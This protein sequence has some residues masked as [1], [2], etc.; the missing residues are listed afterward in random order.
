[1]YI[2]WHKCKCSET[3]TYS[4]IQQAYIH[5]HVQISAQVMLKV[6]CRPYSIQTTVPSFRKKEH[7]A[8]HYC[9]G[10]TCLVLNHISAILFFVKS[11]LYLGFVFAG[12]VKKKIQNLLMV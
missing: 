7:F 1:M 2:H 3:G 5:V 9:K 6:H 10:L 4:Y 11:F 8:S 12:K